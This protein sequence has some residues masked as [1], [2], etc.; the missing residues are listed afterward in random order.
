MEGQSPVSAAAKARRGRPRADGRP[1]ERQPRDEIVA[2]A[3]RLFARRGVA[4]TTMSEIASHSGLRQSSLYYYF[5]DKEAILE[6]I[7]RT[8]NRAV[9]DHLEAVNAD[10]G[11]PALR[12]Y[13]VLRADARQ[14]CGFPYDI[15]EVYR[16]ST[17]QHERF[18]RFWA[19]R[20]RL[21]DEVAALIAEGVA[22]GDFVEVDHRLAALTLLS[23][24]E[25]TQN[26]FRTVGPYGQRGGEHYSAE[27]VGT[28]LADLALGA[29]L[30][31]RGR[32]ASLRRAAK[33]HDP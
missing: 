23:S 6:E 15:N 26:W 32:L 22:S 30:R 9:L 3:S 5:R 2:V 7:L 18:T 4:A 8:V 14:I 12:L 21:N 25:G 29:L 31:R 28:F 27:D 1:L 33:R 19:D 16:I 20:Q 24:D 11:S 17:L 13:R 10:G